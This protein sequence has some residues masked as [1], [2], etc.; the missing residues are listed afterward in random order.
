[1]G[2]GWAIYEISARLGVDCSRFVAGLDGDRK[3]SD[4]AASKLGLLASLD[5]SSSGSI[6]RFIFAEQ[7]SLV[8]N[9]HLIELTNRFR[10]SV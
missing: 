4:C 8:D 7:V 1:V 5:T 3:R 10:I 9:A 2:G 6:W